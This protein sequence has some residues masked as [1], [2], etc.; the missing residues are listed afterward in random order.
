[1]MSDSR[2]RQGCPT[3]EPPDCLMSTAAKFA[4]FTYITKFDKIL[5]SF[6]FH[7]L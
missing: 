2:L 5:G 6:M 1:M 3:H 7:L 4:N